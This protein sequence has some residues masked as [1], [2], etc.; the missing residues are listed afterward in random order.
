MAFIKH[1]Q[2]KAVRAAR[3]W[4]EGMENVEDIAISCKRF[5]SEPGSFMFT[6]HIT[7]SAYYCTSYKVFLILT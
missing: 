1:S 3:I 2:T 7:E 6:P 4:S 5:R